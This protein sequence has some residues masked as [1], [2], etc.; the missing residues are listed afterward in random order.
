MDPADV[1]AIQRFERHLGARLGRCHQS[2]LV[3]VATRA[4]D[5]DYGGRLGQNHTSEN[6]GPVDRRAI[7]PVAGRLAGTNGRASTSE[8]HR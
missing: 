8:M 5:I 3:G 4:V 1:H 2:S 6:P 7:L